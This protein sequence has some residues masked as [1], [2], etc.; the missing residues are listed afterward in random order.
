MSDP[1]LAA[2]HGLR[3]VMDT[4]KLSLIHE[5]SG[6]ALLKRNRN[7]NN[8]HPQTSLVPLLTSMRFQI[9]VQ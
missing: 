2:G 9:S 1:I 4:P 8:C 3:W 5:I 7:V 6:K